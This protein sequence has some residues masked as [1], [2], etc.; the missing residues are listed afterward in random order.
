MNPGDARV[1]EGKRL[2]AGATRLHETGVHAD[3][4]A[5]AKKAARVLGVSL[6]L[7]DMT[8][9]Q[10]EQVRAAEQRIGN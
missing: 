2:I 6:K 5:T 3:S 1:K 10:A 9:A 7:A 4:I 8:P